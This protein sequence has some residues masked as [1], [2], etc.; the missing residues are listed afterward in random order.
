MDAARKE[1]EK[2]QKT[3]AFK[4]L[5]STEEGRNEALTKDRTDL[6]EIAEGIRRPFKGF[7]FNER[8]AKIEML[9]EMAEQHMMGPEGRST[10]YRN[11]YNSIMRAYENRNN[12]VDNNNP[13]ENGENELQNIF[14]NTEKYMKDPVVDKLADKLKK[15]G[16]RR[17]LFDGKVN[18]GNL[19]FDRLQNAYDGAKKELEAAPVL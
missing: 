2:L 13:A 16:D 19:N 9:K 11:M 7:T 6:A 14:D 5:A 10:K 1:A 15:S 4:H 8:K 12:L 18:F 3:W 17:N